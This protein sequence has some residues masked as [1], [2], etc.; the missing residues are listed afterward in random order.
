MASCKT[1]GDKAQCKAGM[2]HP[3]CANCAAGKCETHGCPPA[4]K[5]ACKTGA[6][7]CKTEGG[8]CKTA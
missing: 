3:D 7:S 5:A 1:D 6:A 4:D 2:C 8:S